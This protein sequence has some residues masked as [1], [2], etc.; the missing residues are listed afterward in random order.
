MSGWR[1][2]A[3][4]E[5]Y[6]NPWIRV[7]EDEVTRPDGTQGIYGVVELR[8]PAVFVVALTDD[9]EVV[10]VGV[11]RYPAG[12]LSWEV[13]AGG[14]DGEDPVSAADRELRE[15]AGLAAREY[16][17]LG[18]VDS[19][20]GIADAP[21]YV[22][23]ARGLTPVDAHGQAEEGITGVRRVAWPELLTTIATGGITDGESLAA[24]LHAAIALGRVR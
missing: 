13:P 20:N 24:L 17:V 2:N 21:G 1:T 9:D 12:R 22:V 4:R 23:L 7:R 10:L 5:V 11:D 19:L 6:G 16:Q 14:T 18:A 8:H 3:T 15:E